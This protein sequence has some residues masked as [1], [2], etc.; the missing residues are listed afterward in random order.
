MKKIA[1]YGIS[2]CLSLSL[3]AVITPLQATNFEGK[4]DEYIEKCSS[5]TLTN[6]DKAVCTE[7]NEYLK[8]KNEDLK[9]QISDSE[10]DIA[11]TQS[12]IDTVEQ[13]LITLND[14]II[15]KE[16]EIAYLD[17]SIENLQT[18]IDERELEVKDRMYAMQSYI[19]T[20]TYI[21]FIFGATN[22]ADMMSRM[23]SVEELTDYDKELILGLFNDKTL[24]E[25]QRATANTVKA[26]LEEQKIQQAA[27][28]EQHIALLNEQNS[29]LKNQQDASAN[30]EEVTQGI[31][32]AMA[33][34]AETSKENEIGGSVNVTGDSEV[35]MAIAQAALTQRGKPYT[36]GATGPNS[37]DCSG[38]VYW[39]FNQAGVSIGRTTAQGY[40][41]YGQN[42][43]LSEAQAGDVVTF[44]GY[45]YV[46]HIGIIVDNNGT[47]VH[48]AGQANEINGQWGGTVRVNNVHDVGLSIHNVRRMY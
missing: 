48:A 41:S 6:S 37:Y 26:N 31:T 47:V 36:W 23:D 25:E 15:A 39:A 1:F 44:F 35:G 16:G 12:D 17:T 5:S 18:S 43:S 7:F 19:N 3:L 42:I 21:D 27:L 8:D 45:G 28:Q 14:D 34:I 40:S 33:Q 22:F 9:N 13:T 24:I 32:D 38:L 30:L 29:T 46:C 11:N 4:E 10:T 2:A 20:N